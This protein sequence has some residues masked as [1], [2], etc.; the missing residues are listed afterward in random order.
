LLDAVQSSNANGAVNVPP[1]TA[2][3]TFDEKPAP[4]VEFGL[5]GVG[6]VK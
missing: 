3:S 2:N 4:A 1:F 5:P 6:T